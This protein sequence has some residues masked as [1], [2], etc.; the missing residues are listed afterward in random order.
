M[1]FG[2][3]KSQ[4]PDAESA[5]PGRDTRTF[6]VG[7][8]HAVLGN[9]IEGAVPEGFEEAV[10]G[11]GCFWGAEKVFWQTPGVWSTAAGYAGGITRNPTY[12]QVCSGRTGHAEVVRVVYD[13]AQVSYAQ[14]LKTFW[15][16]HDPTQG[17]QQGN[18]VGTQ[19]RSIILTTSADQQA[20]A[21]KSRDVF[22]QSLS[23]QRYGEIST[24]I[25]P[26]EAFWFAEAE[27]QQ[28]LHKNPYGYCP[29]HATGVTC[30]IG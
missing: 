21:E 4:L 24:S 30:N 13:P 1:L 8:R 29:V 22:Q 10:F 25:V 11:L 28:Y 9:P 19:Y 2:R 3:E 15:E 14:L 7:D 5:L 27:H 17:M 6:A 12:E 26:L 16:D 23:A 18:D 20:E